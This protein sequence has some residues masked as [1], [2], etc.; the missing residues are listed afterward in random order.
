M[1]PKIMRETFKPDLPRRT[2]CHIQS[3]LGAKSELKRLSRTVRHTLFLPRFGH[4]LDIVWDVKV[5][6]NKKQTILCS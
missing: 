3:T 4:L 6:W 5:E 1:Q 2:V